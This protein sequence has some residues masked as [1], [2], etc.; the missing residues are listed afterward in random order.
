MSGGNRPVPSPDVPELV[1]RRYRV[2]NQIG[3]GGMGTVYRA[4][5]RLTG[6]IVTLKRV[7]GELDSAGDSGSRQQEARVALA[8]EFQVLAGLRHP[9]VISVLDYGFEQGQPYFT[10]DLQEG[11]QGFVAGAR[12]QPL[13]VQVDLVVQLLQALSYL[14]RRGI[15]H[16][17]VKPSNVLVVGGQVKVL[18]FGISLSRDEARASE[19]VEGTP[20]YLA[21]EVLRGDAPSRAGDLYAVGVMLYELMVGR[22]PFALEDRR[23]LLAEV[24]ARE[25][26]LR[27]PDLDARLV[28]VLR[29][30]LSKDPEE[31]FG[32][33]A[34]AVIY[35][36]G[37]ALGRK[38][39]VQTTHTRE[40]LLQ[41]APLVGREAEL[42]RIKGLIARVVAGEAGGA[43][44][45][46]GESGVGKS[47]LLAEA[48]TLGLVRGALVLRGQ[49]VREGGSPFQVLREPVRW[50][51]VLD[52]PSDAEIG[53]LR[54]VVPDLGVVLGRVVEPA[55]PAGTAQDTLADPG[56]ARSRPV[57]PGAPLEAGAIFAR[58]LDTLEDL[59]ARQAQP[60]V[61]LLEDLQWAGGEALLAIRR[62]A[63]LAQRR[64]LL[65][66]GAWRDD[67]L[68][69]LPEQV[70]EAEVLRL[71]RLP[72]YAVAAL[73]RF[74]LGDAGARPETVALL[75][76]ETEGNAYFVVEAMRAIL[77]EGGDPS[78]VPARLLAG[79]VGR[80]AQR[81]LARV[82]EADLAPLRAA[83]VVGRQIDPEVMAKVA[84]ALDLDAWITRLANAAVLEPYEQ[85][86]RFSH[87][88]LRDVLLLQVG[89]DERRALH[90]AVAEALESL[91]REAG[92]P[93]LA[94]HWAEAG[95]SARELRWRVRAAEAG[96][97]AGAWE[98]ARRNLER[99]LE[100]AAIQ[101][102]REVDLARWRR[103]TA[104]CCYLSGDDAAAFAHLERVMAAGGLALPRS[105]GALG[106]L[107]LRQA[108][109]QLRQQISPAP[110]AVE[111]QRRAMLVE[112][113]RAAGRLCQSA[114]M[115]SDQLGV[116]AYSLLAVNLADRAGFTVP[117]AL[118]V[119]AFAAA[120][121]RLRSLSARFFDRARAAAA[122]DAFTFVEIALLET[123]ALVGAGRLAEAERRADVALVEAQ[124]I[125]HR[126]GVAGLA[127]IRVQCCRW[128]RASLDDGALVVH[129]AEDLLGRGNPQ[130]AQSAP[131]VG[132]YWLL[133][134]RGEAGAAFLERAKA[135]LQ[136]GQSLVQLTVG[137]ALALLWS[138]LGRVREAAAEVRA[139]AA[140]FLDVG[141]IPPVCQHVFTG[142]CE[143]RLLAWRE[144]GSPETARLAA[145]EARAALGAYRRWARLYPVGWPEVWRFTGELHR[146]A[147][148]LDRARRAL[149]RAVDLSRSAGQPLHEALALLALGRLQSLDTE[150]RRAHLRAARA[151]LEGSGMVWHLRQIDEAEARIG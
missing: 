74:A 20:A 130:G 58:L 41:S 36:L 145:R 51:A 138:E 98:E 120:T 56:A 72:P 129:E 4:I 21:P 46:G 61:L 90:R 82:S 66:L 49:A 2:V 108:L 77:E 11:A 92:A 64:P 148:E 65:L 30:L 146:L 34:E 26:D 16:C 96:T 110:V 126:L 106:W 38:L 32:G 132:I 27:S 97:A 94:L 149:A 88:K 60:V 93:A 87:D 99:A 37:E 105:R 23:R 70:P 127:C 89:A 139:R 13:A 119:A 7:I 137:G 45:V 5:D 109:G 95:D 143:A 133:Q 1:G 101:G 48:R 12:G 122:D 24:V 55:A 128:P 71:S 79:G 121:L 42:Q 134:G 78:V 52:E 123:A 69:A 86:W 15:L 107:L 144:A 124:R 135:V 150:T 28:P 73:C 54:P 114:I 18:D 136:E 14:H 19:M 100:L 63:R 91:R 118:G 17:D 10:M 3:H 59:F 53:V 76:R 35:A 81:R 68:P 50:L 31:R 83:A 47:R 117:Y 111:E 142:L 8:R 29:R 116:L 151:L 113:S 75:L 33:D 102:A 43:L 140:A 112:M 131:F 9:N 115:T 44:L 103:Q 84:P 104:E 6:Q 40:S 39:A 22:H 85:K 80:I 125:Q 141:S 57:A 147:G 25:P 67:E 62:L